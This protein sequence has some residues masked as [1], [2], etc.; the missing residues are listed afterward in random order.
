MR[1]VKESRFRAPVSRLFA[2]HER[3]DVLQL[4]TPP[5]LGVEVGSPAPS[6][7]PGSRTRFRVRL[8]PG[9]W[10]DSEAEHVAYEK[11]VYFED[12]QIRGP[13]RV[14]RHCHFFRADGPDASVLRDDIEYEP[15][16]GAVG[17]LLAPLLVGRRLEALF[18][19]R[20]D[21]T[22]KEIEK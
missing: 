10:I 4:L 8:A 19:H 13:F 1:F 15:P 22:R 14:W 17:R 20:H 12:R 3:K 5:W 9:V 7:A 21:I 16:F 6:L 11:D 2:F 18:R